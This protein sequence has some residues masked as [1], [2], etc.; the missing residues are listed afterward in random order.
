MV[1]LDN[2]S[3]GH[4]EAVING[5]LIVGDIGDKEALDHVFSTHSI[6]AV[7][8]FAAF[9]YVNESVENPA[10]YYLNNVSKGLVL[11]EAMIRHN[12]AKLI[13]SST[14]AV[15]GEP[16]EI[17]LTE[18]H[19]LAPVNPYGYTKMVFEQ[20]AMDLARS[21]GLRP[22]FLR[23]FNAAGADPEG[24]LGEDHD[25]E[26]HLIPLVI[27]AALGKREN[28]SVFGTDYPTEDGTCI[29][30]YIHINDL[31]D[32]HIKA[33]DY[34]DSS[35]EPAT[36]NLGNGNGYSVR[37]VIDTVVKLS[38]REVSVIDAPRRAGDPAILIGSS[39]KAQSVLGWRPE[40]PDL[41]SIVETA[42]N[43][44]TSRL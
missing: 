11:L 36:F 12:V 14:C 4:A 3:T 9:A 38:G 44:H 41:E 28:I 37:Q 10:K 13:F 20:M 6:H 34:L 15:Y 42:L 32:A 29:R 2:L 19:P 30:D 31:I 23:Y 8:H 1:I 39:A 27:D 25:P 26:T 33:L 24:E 18:E 35:D 17:P 5:N 22:L 7:V 21:S 43:W 40:Y 16:N